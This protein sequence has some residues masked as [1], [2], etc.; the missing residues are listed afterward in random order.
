MSEIDRFEYPV[1]RAELNLFACLFSGQAFGW[2][3]LPDGS[4][5]GFFVDKGE[6]HRARLRRSGDRIVVETDAGED[7]F[8][9]YFNLHPRLQDIIESFPGDPDLAL[10]V[11]RFRGLRVLRQDPW[12]ALV[13]FMVSQNNNISRIR[14]ILRRALV[15][16]GRFPTPEDLVDE[17]GL[18]GL[19][20]GYRA[21]YLSCLGR[22][23]LEGRFD[24][25]RLQQLDDESALRELLELKGVGPKVAACALL[26]GYGRN[27]AFPVDVWIARQ[28]KPGLDYGPYAGWGQLY[29]Y[30]LARGLEPG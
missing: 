28:A 11:R 21:G 1:E 18:E 20:L 19:G 3:A 26:Y 22:A 13:S 29:L 24:P 14:L 10:A 6:T 7:W 15:A 17:R 8:Q 4:F 23:V 27:R 5:E 9:R 2:D 30:A 25:Y 16:F 12:E